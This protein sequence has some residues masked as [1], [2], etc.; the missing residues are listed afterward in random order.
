MAKRMLTEDIHALFAALKAAN[1][2]PRSELHY[3]TPFQLAVAVLL[4][5]QSTDQGVNRV[6]PALFTVAPTPEALLALGEDGIRERIRSLGLFNNKARNLAALAE[7]LVRDHGGQLPRDREAL[8]A[9][10]GIGRKSANVIL[11]VVYGEPTLAVDTH[12]FRVSNR[13]GL[14]AGKTPEA[15]EKGLLAVVPPAFLLH[16]HHWLILHGR[17]V[18]QAKSPRCGECLIRSWC[19][20]PEKRSA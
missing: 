14:A 8:Q 13:T 16:A 15:V 6:T 5:A 1:P 19:Q 2:E 20:W 18:C 3:R 4:S 7:I 12:V 10:P 9:L 17:H 11:N